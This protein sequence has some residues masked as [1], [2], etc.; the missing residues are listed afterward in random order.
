MSHTPGPWVWDEDSLY[1]TAVPKGTPAIIVLHE[2]YGFASDGDRLLIKSAPDLLA[3]LHR[4][5]QVSGD[6][7]IENIASAAIAKAEHGT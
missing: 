1:S 5:F 3:A 7:I 6:P 4:I 2:A